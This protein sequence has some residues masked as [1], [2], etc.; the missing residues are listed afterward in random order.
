MI[1]DC[2]QTTFLRFLARLL[3]KMKGYSS[4]NISL[5]DQ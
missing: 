2:F 1:H 4:A 5:A 3:R